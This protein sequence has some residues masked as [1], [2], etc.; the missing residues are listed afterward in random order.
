MKNKFEYKQK[1]IADG[2][3]QVNLIWHLMK[4]MKINF[5]VI[6]IINDEN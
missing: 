3:F 4:V 1:E 6:L 5:H 2:I